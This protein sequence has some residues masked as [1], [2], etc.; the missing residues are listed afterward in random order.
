MALRKLLIDCDPG[1]DDILAILNCLAHPEAFEILGYTTVCGNQLVELVTRNLCGVLTYLGVPGSVAQ[2]YDAPMVLPPDPQPEAHG[3]T[4][5]DGPHLP[6]PT[7]LPLPVHALDFL[8]DTLLAHDHVTV[9]ALAPLTNLAMLLKTYP[10]VKDHIDCITLMGGSRGGGNILPRAEFNLYADPHAAKVVFESGVPIV[11]SDIEICQ[12]CATP[13]TWIDSLR[14]QGRVQ[15]LV[16][17]ILQFFSLWGRRHGQNTSPIFDLV[18][19]MHMLHPE[20]FETAPVR[21]QIE[22]EGRLTRGMT[23]V[24]SVDNP[25]TA[26]VT[27]LKSCRDPAAYNRYLAENLVLLNQQL[28]PEA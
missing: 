3:I 23:I 15:D 21:V 28:F 26:N 22:T 14:G 27:L 5:L 8:R 9:V 1:H 19:V 20:L 16:H 13:H 18:P 2:G 17:D 25:Q 12:A 24:D 7:V 10:A 6:E 11:M 4:G